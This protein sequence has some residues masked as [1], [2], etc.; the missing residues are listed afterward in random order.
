M[1]HPLHLIQLIS[2][3]TVPNLLP[4]L[5]LQ[6]ASVTHLV[7]P[8]TAARSRHLA[9]AAR[10]VGVNPRVEVV[11]LSD[12]PG[13]PE[14]CA[15]VNDAISHAR[16]QGSAPVLNFTGGT[17]LMSIGAYAAAM[18]TKIPSLYVD[19]QDD[20]FVNGGSS[21]EMADLLENDWSFTPLRSQIRVDT[22][23]IANGVERVTGGKPWKDALS[24]ARHLS[25]NMEDQTA[26]HEA[27]H[28][29]K[30]VFPHGREPRKPV[31]WLKVLDQ[32]I[33]LPDAVAEA[34]AALGLVRKSGSDCFLPDASR[35]ELG[36][37]NT[38]SKVANFYPRYFAAVAPFQATTTFLTGGWWEVIVAEA[39][40][41]AGLFRDIRWSCQVGQRNGPD[42]EEDIL[43]VDGVR[44]CYVSCKRGGAKAKLLPL[45][46]EVRS[47][48]N[49]IGGTFSRRF[50][51]VWDPP[52]NRT[53]ANLEQ[54]ARE[55][56]IRLITRET[57]GSPNA[58]LD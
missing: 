44:L 13:I 40:A 3:Q 24:L 56:G 28:G 39:M 4:I 10:A 47:R 23:A 42:L 58:F 17:K 49:R 22:L 51:A 1:N 55:L 19:T 25:E 20:C 45:L 29:P 8:F 14:T 38:Q 54:R 52:R 57:I 48:A 32:P 31:D 37:L 16:E 26:T 7:T 21:T 35:K 2:E 15:V 43:A 5:R 12:M 46:E 9:D 30:G 27:F 6:P 11:N 53:A 34:A 41:A 33:R 36:A 50:L 18:Q